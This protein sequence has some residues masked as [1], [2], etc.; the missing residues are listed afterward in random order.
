VLPDKAYQDVIR[1]DAHQTNPLKVPLW[2]PYEQMP[3]PGN[4]GGDDYVIEANLTAADGLQWAPQTKRYGVRVGPD[5][6]TTALSFRV[7]TSD[8]RAG[9][10]FRWQSF[11]SPPDGAVLTATP[12]K[13][14]LWDV[15]KIKGSTVFA[16][17]TID[18]VARIGE[19]AVT[20]KLKSGAQVIPHP[21]SDEGDEPHYVE[22]EER[23]I[24][25]LSTGADFLLLDKPAEWRIENEARERP[26]L[27]DVEFWAEAINRMGQRPPSFRYV[28]ELPFECILHTPTGTQDQSFSFSLKI[29]FEVMRYAGDHA[30]AID[31]GTSAVVAAFEQEEQVIRGRHND[32][33][34]ATQNLQERYLE[35]VKTWQG[36]PDLDLRDV[37]DFENAAPNME[38]HTAFIPS[39]LLMRDNKEIGEADFVILPVSSMQ[40]GKAWDRTVYY[41]KGL[42][43]RGDEVLDY[44]EVKGM[45]PLKWK[46]NSGAER[47]APKDAIK[48]DEIIRSAYRNL[49]TNY[50]EPLL[51]R[52]DKLDYLDRLVVS[53]PNNF[54]V[55]HIRRVSK[56]LTETFP[57]F[58]S[59]DLLS[60]SNAVAVYCARNAT[61]FFSKVPHGGETRH[62]LVC[63]IGAGTADLTYS[64]L[65]W[66]SVQ[67]ASRLKEMRVLFKTG[68]PVAGNR[69]DICL[70]KVVDAKIRTLIG[71]LK[72]KGIK[73]D[74]DNPIVD[75]DETTFNPSLYAGSMIALKQRLL[76]L[77]TEISSL[78]KPN[79]EIQITT[80]RGLRKGIVSM[81]V[82]DD[83]TVEKL[84]ELGITYSRNKWIGIPLS[85]EDIFEHP[86][87]VRWLKQVTH[88]LI[89][90]LSGALKVL[91]LKP[92]IDTLIL[93]GR[94]AQFPPLRKRLHATLKEILGLEE[95]AYYA[96]KLE[97]NENK[98]AVALG[99][100]LYAIFHENDLQLIDRNIWAKYGI[101][102]N[103][104]STRRFKEF[105]S[106]ASQVLPE[107][108]EREI[109]GMKTVFFSRTMM[110]SRSDGPIQIAATHSE[111]PDSALTDF[112]TY[113]DSFQVLHT[114]GAAQLGS[115]GQL[116]IRMANNRNDT[117]T[118]IIDPDG[119]SKKVVVRGY[120]E[121]AHLVQMDW[122]YR[123]LSS[124]T[125]PGSPGNNWR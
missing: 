54:T 85:Q 51:Q 29:D 95:S 61:R 108:E 26:I 40:M 17:I 71:V 60:E 100:L 104:G 30:L 37:L 91:G 24:V 115:P 69:L 63:D 117:I 120:R 10:E 116:K 55:S 98:E 84:N 43:L 15:G 119:V 20:V 36:S 18:N 2:L 34:F 45:P 25:R 78:E 68:I 32:A 109:N 76:Q 33:S 118:V 59:I 106:Y 23:K 112:Q 31:F 44:R 74:Y 41:L 53:Y 73:L 81:Q 48:V 72:E 105:F 121:D 50:V 4:I 52:Q 35:L 57:Q 58:R 96:P 62:L 82:V 80:E 5:Q 11:S 87:T 111:D 83:E 13:K 107:D 21:A 70:A 42:I 3:P 93:S 99:S 46:D 79:Y 77:K 49:I 65:L 47:I 12:S 6:R 88:E 19:G 66:E 110:I 114:V 16:K 94:T 75:P 9:N 123:P 56:I 67:G 124:K 7:G 28:C 38:S 125:G 64:R 90:N 1:V 8:Q 89:Q 14:V 113:L 101:I 122:P 27:L 102:Y 22:G 39:P 86:E 92:E 97:S 103:D